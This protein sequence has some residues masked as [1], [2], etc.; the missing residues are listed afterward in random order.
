MAAMQGAHHSLHIISPMPPH[1]ERGT[2]QPSNSIPLNSTPVCYPLLYEPTPSSPTLN[3]SSKPV[4]KLLPGIQN[5]LFKINYQKYQLN[6]TIIGEIQE[7][8][9]MSPA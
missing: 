5:V 8:N 6:Y 9:V 1:S 7:A 4:K 3:Q 2:S